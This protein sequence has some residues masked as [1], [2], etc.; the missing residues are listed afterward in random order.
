MFI[1]FAAWKSE[2]LI[3]LEV[4]APVDDRPWSKRCCHLSDSLCEGIDHLL[5]ASLFYQQSGVFPHGEHHVLCSQETYTVRMSLP[6]D[7]LG[8]LWEL[9]VH[10]DLC[11]G[12]WDN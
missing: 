12:Y 5:A 9:D 11:R 2:E 8:E 10:V 3:R 1:F 7:L 4:K 6:F